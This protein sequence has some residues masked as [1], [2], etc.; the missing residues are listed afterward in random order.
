MF[1]EYKAL[2]NKMWD[3]YR[4]LDE[5]STHCTDSTKP[6]T[7]EEKYAAV[8]LHWLRNMKKE[9]SWCMNNQ[10]Y[11]SPK[12]YK[13]KP[14]GIWIPAPREACLATVKTEETYANK[15]DKNYVRPIPYAWW[16][17]CKSYEHCLFLV[18]HR[19]QYF[20]RLIDPLRTARIAA[21]LS[22]GCVPALTASSDAVAAAIVPD[23][24]AGKV[25]E[26]PK[27]EVTYE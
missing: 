4:V 8:V 13:T 5:A 16:E 9:L 18:Q 22:L 14:S 17:H 27:Q 3:S 10:C 23:W 20:A 12:G 24:C 7:E 15:H 1:E 2:R 21:A 25:L 11:P 6:P 26:V 19:K